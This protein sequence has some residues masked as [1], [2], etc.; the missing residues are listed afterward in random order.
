MRW[1]LKKK[2][3]S[4][5]QHCQWNPFNQSY[6]SQF[7][8]SCFKGDLGKL[9][10]YCE[11]NDG[12]YW[13][14]AYLACH[15]RCPN[16]LPVSVSSLYF[17]LLGAN[18]ECDVDSLPSLWESTPLSLRYEKDL[19]LVRVLRH[20]FWK[21]VSHVSSAAMAVITPLHEG[22]RQPQGI[23]EWQLLPEW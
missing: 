4:D 20:L 21:R 10:T 9:Q 23:W 5:L 12:N 3:K 17:I 15:V 22:N 13:D 16:E 7:L 1:A 8:P 19:W 6:S 2:R 18:W 11:A 14:A